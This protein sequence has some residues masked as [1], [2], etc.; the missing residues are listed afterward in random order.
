M[1]KALAS[2]DVDVIR[3]VRSK[4]RRA[5][6]SRWRCCKVKFGAFDPSGAQCNLDSAEA[7]YKKYEYL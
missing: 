5:K 3:H 6:S 4:N 1:H 7:T 2:T